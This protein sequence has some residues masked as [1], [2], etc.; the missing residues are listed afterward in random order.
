MKQSYPAMVVQNHRY[1]GPM[2]SRKDSDFLEDAFGAITHLKQLFNDNAT[3]IKAVATDINNMNKE[4]ESTH[5]TFHNMEI[6]LLSLKGGEL[7]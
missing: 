3:K 4:E 5:D 1:R 6:R 7:R 2:E